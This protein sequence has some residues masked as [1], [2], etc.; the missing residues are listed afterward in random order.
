MD[1][2]PSQGGCIG[3]LIWLAFWGVIIGTVNAVLN[4]LGIW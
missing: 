3:C 4:A 1:D 2:N